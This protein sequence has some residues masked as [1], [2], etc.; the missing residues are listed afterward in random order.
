VISVTVCKNS[1]LASETWDSLYSLSIIVAKIADDRL[2]DALAATLLAAKR[3][4]R[5]QRRSSSRELPQTFYLFASSSAFVVRFAT[6]SR[7]VRNGGRGERDREE[8]R[9]GQEYRRQ[10]LRPLTALIV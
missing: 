3:V 4:C 6:H 5:F 7:K 2:V 1:L 8:A 10:S 9:Q